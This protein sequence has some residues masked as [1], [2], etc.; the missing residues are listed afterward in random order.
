MDAPIIQISKEKAKELY[1]DYAEV[2]LKRKEKYLED[3][4]KVYL[5]LSKGH[6]IIDIYEA[7]KTS[8]IREDGEPKLAIARADWK[9]VFFSKHLGGSGIFDDDGN[10]W[11]EYV[12]DVVL[13]GGTFPSWK[14]IKTPTEWNP[15]RTEIEKPHLKIKVPLIPAHL[16]PSGALKNYYILFEVEKWDEVPVAKDPFL[17]RRINSNCFLVLAEWDLTEVEQAIIRGM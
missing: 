4:K 6:K 10:Q 3:L 14:E 2:V 16:L 7:F 15:E 1:E 5:H 13:P 12:G 8:G 17:L 11:R 9:N